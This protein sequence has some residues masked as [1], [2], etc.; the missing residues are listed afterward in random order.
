MPQKANGHHEKEDRHPKR[1]SGLD[2]NG[3]VLDLSVYPTRA[4]V[5]QLRR[6]NAPVA[7]ADHGL[8]MS[9]LATRDSGL[10]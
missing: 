6:I 5:S 7:S 8:S 10:R 1:L 3:T 4:P 2:V 9:I